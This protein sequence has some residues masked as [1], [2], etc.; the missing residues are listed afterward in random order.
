M[1]LLN[2]PKAESLLYN[3]VS[4]FLLGS[5]SHERVAGSDLIAGLDY[6]F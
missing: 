6:F 3:L 5:L 2:L 1:P 4:L